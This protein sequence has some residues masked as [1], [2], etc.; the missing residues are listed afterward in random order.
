MSTVNETL[1]TD[2]QRLAAL[3]AVDQR[4]KDRR[5]RMAILVTEADG[6]EFELIRQRAAVV[7]MTTERDAL[8]IRRVEM[9]RQLDTLSGKIRDNRMRVNRV[10]NNT[11]LLALQREID[12]SKEA[13]VQ[14]EE[15]LLR[16]METLE[17]LATQLATTRETLQQLETQADDAVATRRAQAESLR[18]EVEAERG[19]R[20][21][22]A[23]GMDPS[24]RGKYE[25]LF[26]RRGGCAVVEARGNIC[27]GCRLHIPPQLYNELQKYRD[28]V[29]QCP[30]CHRILFF[31]PEPPAV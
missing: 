29:R 10:R 20:D 12:L 9:E 14:I 28:V 3:Q 30:N 2:I 6:Y 15:E 26:D 27:T 18:Q 5:D 31:R 4:L 24:L 25:Q 11:E 21:A 13:T 8:E 22:I 23:A 7:A 17:N 19:Q 16:V 1:A